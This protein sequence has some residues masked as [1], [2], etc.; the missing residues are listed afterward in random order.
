MP[1]SMLVSDWPESEAWRGHF[2]TFG[3]VGV[4]KM[5][6]RHLA[7]QSLSVAGVDGLL[8]PQEPSVAATWALFS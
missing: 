2:V 3:L 5:G 1:L 7:P 6:G 8:A 4:P